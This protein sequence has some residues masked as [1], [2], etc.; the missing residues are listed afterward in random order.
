MSRAVFNPSGTVTAF[1]GTV[2]RARSLAEADER[3]FLGLDQSIQ[4]CVILRP[5]QS[6]EPL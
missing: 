6:M 5:N 2:D 3:L 1:V 4:S